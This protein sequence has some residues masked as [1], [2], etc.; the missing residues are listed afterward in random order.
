MS[1]Y[2]GADLTASECEYLESNIGK[3]IEINGF[4]STS[5]SL[6]TAKNFARQRNNNTIFKINFKKIP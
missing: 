2:R 4:I 6:E 1:V 5:K 3:Y